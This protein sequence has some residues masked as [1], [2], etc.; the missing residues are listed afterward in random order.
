MLFA[1]G[2]TAAI[3]STTFTMSG[4]EVIG[5]ISAVIG[6]IDASIKIYDSAQKDVKLSETFHMV[7]R[8]LPIIL[9]TLQTCKDHL[10]PI[11]GSLPA[12][13]CKALEKTLDACDEKA[14]K[15]RQ[16]FEKVLPGEKDAWERRYVKIVQRLGKGN[17]VE[18]LMTSITE[19]VQLVVNNHA[20]QSTKP[21]QNAE[22]EKI[23]QEMKSVQSSMPGEE[24]SGMSFNSGGGHMENYVN[25]DK[26]YLVVNRDRV[27]TQHFGNGK[28]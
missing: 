6:I 13:V 23:V 26:G 7:G 3:R 21:E 14:G 10:E 11:Q 5:G 20:V 18:E 4:L 8:R 25:Q 28:N 19:D 17:K 2:H 9:N 16:I 1:R 22:L 15:L 27:Q 12:D 24:S